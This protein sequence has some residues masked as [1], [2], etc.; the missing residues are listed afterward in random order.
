M[1]ARLARPALAI[2]ALAGLCW[3][4]V[5]HGFPQYDTEYALVWGD[6]LA[7]GN[8]PDYGAPIPPTPH[9]LADV[10]GLLLSPL[11]TGAETATVILAYLALGAVGYL[12]FRLGALWFDPWI[13]A[14]AALVV[15]TREPLLSDGVRA[16]VD[17]PYLALVLGALALESQRRRRGAPVLAL[18]ALAGLLRPE[19]WLFSAAYLAYLALERDPDRGRLRL[20]WRGERGSRELAALAALALAAPIAWGAFDWI[21]ADD[22]LYSFTGTRNTVEALGRETGLVDLIAYGPRRLGEV[23]RE[24]GLLAAAGGLVLGLAFLRGRAVLGTAAAVLAAAAFSILAIAGLAIIPRYLL[25]TA[26]ILAV[27]CAV[28]LLGWRQLAPGHPWRRRWQWFAALTVLVFLA[29]TP[30]QV[31]LIS[32]LRD[33]VASQDRIGDDL[34]RLADD[35]DFATGCDPISVPNHRLVPILS[36]ALDRT[37]SQIISSSEQ[38]QPRRGYFVDPATRE[39]AHDFVLD[40]NDPRRLITGVPPRFELQARNASWKLYARC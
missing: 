25:L 6:Q 18:L 16:Y 35:G 34:G 20:R 11:G 22:P 8:K 9:P 13:G 17:I 28:G 40:P 38:R 23:L 3:L 36:L 14:V 4:L 31:D 33:S 39:V 26:A 30:H 24:P 19:A 37:P 1:L 2:P 27:F 7:H 29:L 12:V 21:I 10:W 15:L 32:D 5:P